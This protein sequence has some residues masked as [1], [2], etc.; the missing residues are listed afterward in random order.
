LFVEIE[1]IRWSKS[2][3]RQTRPL[4]DLSVRR[5]RVRLH[6]RTDLGALLLGGKLVNVDEFTTLSQFIRRVCDRTTRHPQV[7]GDVRLRVL[8]DTL[9]VFEEGLF[10]RLAFRPIGEVAPAYLTK[11]SPYS[12]RRL[13]W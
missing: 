8:G 4:G 6:V 9:R 13:V 5:R 11:Q 2:V 10:H 12:V 3:I 1:G 7:G